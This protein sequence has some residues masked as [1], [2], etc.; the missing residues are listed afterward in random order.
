MVFIV[1]FHL[2]EELFSCFLIDFYDF[3]IVLSFAVSLLR[4]LYNIFNTSI[5]DLY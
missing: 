1:R 3:L 2:Y 5:F 4:F